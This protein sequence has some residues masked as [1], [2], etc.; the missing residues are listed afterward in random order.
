MKYIKLFLV[1]ALI[2]SSH[3]SFS[4]NKYLKLIDKEKYSKASKKLNKAICKS[5]EDIELNYS[6]SVLFSDEKYNKVDFKKA[7]DYWVLS[8]NHF[9]S[10]TDDKEIRSL[11]KVPI[12]PLVFSDLIDSICRKALPEVFAIDK[13][14][15]Y[16]KYLVDFNEVPSYIKKEVI[17]KRDAAAFK[18]ASSINT[19]KSLEFFISKYP[20]AIQISQAIT[21]RNDISYKT[22]VAKD[23]ING[24]K[25]FISKYP[26]AVQVS[27]AWIRV[28]ELAYEESAKENTSLAY[29]KFID[30]YPDSKQFVQAHKL[31]EQRQFEENTGAQTK[32]VYITFIEKYSENSWVS[33]A[34]DSILSIAARTSDISAIKYCVD[35]FK[36]EQ[37]SKALFMLHDVFTNDGEKE[38]L[39]LFYEKY[40]D[41]VLSDLKEKDYLL[42]RYA[43]LLYLSLPYNKKSRVQY[44]DYIK[45]AAPSERAFIALQRIISPSIVS[46]DWTTALSIVKTYES[47]FS[48]SN[49]KLRDL[50]ALLEG[51]S[52]NAIKINSVGTG[53]NIEK[54]LEYLPVISADDKT[55]F[56]CGMDRKDNAGGEDIFTSKKIGGI[57]NNSKIVFELS[58]P[59]SNDAPLNISSDGN[60]MLLFKSGKIYYS[61]KSAYG[62]SQL[63]SFPDNINSGSWQADANISSNGKALLFVSTKKGGYN[64]YPNHSSAN[65]GYHGDD[66][67]PA[68][69]YV[70][71]LDENGEWGDPINLGPTINTK[72]CDRSP[73]LHPDMK[74]LYFSSDGHGGLGKLDVFKSTRLSDTCWDCWSKPVNMGK[75]INT[76]N[77]DW[78]YKISTDGDKAYFAKDNPQTGQ[79]NIY[80]LKLPAY[81]RPNFVATL[82]GQ[83]KDKNNQPISAEIKWE[84]LET[85]KIIGTSKSDPLDGSYFVI[86]PLGK[87]YGYY[88]DKAEYFPASNNIDLRNKN[89]PVE[90]ESDVNM[91]TFKEMKDDGIAVPINN[92]FFDFAKSEL[93]SYSLP[94]LRRVAKII[95]SNNI[96]IEISGHTDNVGDTKQN[97]ILSEQRANSVKE[98]LIREGCSPELLVTIGYGKSHPTASNES[99]IGRS[100]NRRV[101][102][103]FI[104]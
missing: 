28:H 97:Q 101:E 99:E 57:W 73:F 80:W 55:L 71:L 11:N 32:D 77:G 104:K 62:W 94:E 63:M 3:A 84:D 17:E 39:D 56:F 20:D 61:E 41:V 25:E 48:S 82:S 26:D 64:Y 85:G 21:I 72:Y 37:R 33:V 35:N 52:D 34:Q 96:K 98:F 1:L 100:K 47:Y 87:I 54:G 95:R 15:N 50:I 69:I 29:K 103:R 18:I 53:V 10:L 58:S 60:T 16:E 91:V 30:E 38:T 67:Y 46:K 42:A 90:I 83:L 12:N 6:M 93:L 45:L 9:E 70:S 79:S 4:Q 22:T 44:E 14:E 49:M 88:I 23:N 43:D 19:I 7:Y 68:D 2:I 86:L 59:Y 5:P 8:K 51:K 76:E 36:G 65:K 81:L 78:G 31:F 66:Q 74:T 24:Y 75:E 27:R 92:L 89:K 40:N 102:L 13:V